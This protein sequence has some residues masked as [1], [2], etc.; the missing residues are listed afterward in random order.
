MMQVA[1][2][3]RIGGGIVD[4][5]GTN[6]ERNEPA[7]AWVKIKV[8]LI[9]H[10]QIGLL[11]DQW[12]S[13]HALIEINDRLAVRANKCNMM[14]SLGLDFGHSFFSSDPGLEHRVVICS[15]FRNILNN[16]PMVDNFAVLKPKN[17]HNRHTQVAHMARAMIMNNNEIPFC[18]EPLNIHM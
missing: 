17:I 11:K 15:R 5:S 3:L 9:R 12:H 2:V 10:I 14:D 6:K 16:I 4:T 8:H 7:I 18:N 1:D 13:K